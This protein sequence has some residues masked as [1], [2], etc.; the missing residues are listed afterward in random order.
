MSFKDVRRIHFAWP[1]RSA[2]LVLILG[3]VLPI[4]AVFGQELSRTQLEAEVRDRAEEDFKLGR[5]P[6]TVE[7]LQ[8]LFS[9]DAR[10]AGFT[11][12]EVDQLYQN[13]IA[14]PRHG[15]HGGSSSSPKRAG[16]LQSCYSFSLS[17]GT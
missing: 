7:S 1:A 6:A 13:H 2:M 11:I 17:F 16:S 4:A 5:S 9:E 8:I 10:R 3:P 14:T 12:R 15:R